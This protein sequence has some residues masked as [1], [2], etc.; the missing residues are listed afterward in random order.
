[1]CFDTKISYIGIDT[2][3]LQPQ[4]PVF[5]VHLPE[6]GCDDV[7]PLIHT[8]ITLFLIEKENTMEKEKLFKATIR[9]LKYLFGF[10]VL[11]TSIILF[12][13]QALPFMHRVLPSC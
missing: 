1:M 9:S 3:I 8:V 13:I 5:L 12:M 6:L 2:L 4:L 10:H 11:C 7:A